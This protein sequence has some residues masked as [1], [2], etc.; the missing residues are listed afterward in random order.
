MSLSTPKWQHDIG[1][2]VTYNGNGN[3]G[4]SAPTDG[5]SYQPGFNVTVNWA[6]QEKLVKTGYAFC[7]L[8]HQRRT[9]P[10]Q[11]TLRPDTFAMGF[12]DVHALWLIG[13]TIQ[14]YQVSYEA[15]GANYR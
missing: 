8:E 7:W 2:S 13:V 11:S 15:N 1:Y 4:G 10:G 12:A 14:T 3:T 6:I 9:G 5:N